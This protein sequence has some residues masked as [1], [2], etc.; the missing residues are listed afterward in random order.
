MEHTREF[1]T[2]L[3]P[4]DYSEFSELALRYAVSFA[5]DYDSK[6]VV[7]HATPDWF[8]AMGLPDRVSL[9]RATFQSDSE[10]RL[11]EFLTGKIPENI[12]FTTRAAMADVSG[13]ILRVAEETS[14]GLIVMG[15]HGRSGV[16]RFLTGSITY[17]I[18]HKAPVSVLTVCRPSHQFLPPDPQQE[19]QI[20]K[21]LCAIDLESSKEKL[22]KIVCSIAAVYHSE[23]TYLH[24]QQFGE[25]EQRIEEEKYLIERLTWDYAPKIRVSFHVESGHIADQVVRMAVQQQTDLLFVGH[26]TRLPAELGILGSVAGRLVSQSPCPVMV[27]RD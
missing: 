7:A 3:C 2:I 11:K 16:E 23:I 10:S 5:H 9:S 6:L 13:F 24:V 12:P 19:M 18:L 14:A 21:V 17:K 20:R 26:H 22:V 4:V 25:S 15:T 1:Q 8:S 27:V